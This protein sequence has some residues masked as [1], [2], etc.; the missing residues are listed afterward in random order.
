MIPDT[1][2]TLATA[3]L[4]D[5]DADAITFE[6][7]G[8]SADLVTALAAGGITSPFPIQALTIPDALAGRDVCGMAQ[9][10]SGKTL[11]FGL[12]MI[13]RTTTAKRRRPHAVVLVPT[14]ELA[15]QVADE[16]APLAAARGLWL[17]AI[18]GG[19][20]MVRQ[21][22]ALH[23]G[24]DIV[25]AT[26]GRLNDLL[27]RG[28]LTMEAISFVVLDEADQMA[29]MGFLP[30][31]QRILDQVP[32]KPQTL[33]F[34]ATL[35][36][37]AGALVR[38]Y[39]QDPVRL[40]V[41]SE[42]STVDT[43][44]QR[45]IGVSYDDKLDVAARILAGAERAVVFTRTTHGADRLA[46]ALDTAGR[47]ALPI[48]GR[49]NQNQ[50]ERTLAQFAAGDASILVAT[51]VAARGLHVNGVDVVMHF[52]PP[53]DGKTYL[54]RSGRTA[55]AGADGL[56][57]T[58][59]LPDQVRDVVNVQREA[60]VDYAIVPMRPDDE[61]LDDLGAWEAPAGARL[62]DTFRGRPGGG[63]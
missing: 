20:S 2:A 41:V 7:L 11:A 16:L 45:F 34:S 29:D 54:H 4:P 21:I 52:D 33:L 19:S 6:S 24:V 26:P 1:G 17:C 35:D 10:G 48:H 23:A 5:G 14:R 18:Y 38:R 3:A 49:C 53:E 15:N 9:T 30:Q 31:I 47:R 60:G 42:T 13:E 44:K 62:P 57:I 8:L 32:E 50:R 40:E 36:G 55:R 25:I 43:L 28:E 22:R 51:N 58:L 46:A 12:P 63:S 27:E 56:V 39:Q 59:A 37:V 61:R